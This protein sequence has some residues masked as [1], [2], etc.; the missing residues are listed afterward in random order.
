M[1]PTHFS[2]PS[3]KTPAHGSFNIPSLDGIRAG[4]VAIVFIGHTPSIPTWWPGH[5]GVTVFFFLSGFLITTLLRREFDRTQKIRLGN[6]YL[7]RLLRITPPAIFAILLCVWIG[8][9]GILE[10]SMSGWGILAEILNYTNYYMVYVDGHRGLPPESSMLW[11]LAVEEH[12]YLVYPILMILLLKLKATYLQ[13]G[14]ILLVAAL[15]APLWRLYLQLNEA[16][17]YRLYTS[18]DTRYDGLLIGAAMALIWNPSLGDKT[19]LGLRPETIYRAMPVALIIFAYASVKL[20]QYRLTLVDTLLYICLIPVFW[21]V[22]ARPR[23]WLGS[24]LNIPIVAHVGVLSYS[25][26]LIHRLCLGLCNQYIQPTMLANVIALL[27]SLMLAQ[28]MWLLIERPAAKL[29]RK[30]E[31]KASYI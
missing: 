17:F 4:A 6:F 10:S 21:T 13:I 29:R 3:Q 27:L 22:I 28:S 9:R 1:N 5:V 30:L 14:R 2:V 19:P 25:L 18:S 12:F 20:S 16:N 24:L 26:Y 31:S 11:S 7:R 15:C 8:S 23:G